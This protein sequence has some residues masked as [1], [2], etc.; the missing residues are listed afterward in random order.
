MKHISRAEAKFIYT[1]AMTPPSET[2]EM[3]NIAVQHFC[4]VLASKPTLRRILKD[5][6]APQAT[7]VELTV[8]QLR[9]ELMLTFVP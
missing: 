3:V 4:S 8:H 6:M 5:L 1:G 7:P 2:Y 9:F